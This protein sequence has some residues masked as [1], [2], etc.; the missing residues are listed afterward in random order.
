MKEP[1]VSED[2]GNWYSHMLLAE[3]Q[4]FWKTDNIYQVPQIP[5]HVPSEQQFHH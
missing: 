5:N 4:P 3:M 1:C 2:G